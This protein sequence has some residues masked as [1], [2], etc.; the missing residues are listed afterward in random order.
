MNG[1]EIVASSSS[2]AVL[3][4]SRLPAKGWGFLSPDA[5]RERLE[6]E[7]RRHARHL[8]GYGVVR[9][10][11]ELHGLEALVEALVT[12]TRETDAVCVLDDGTFALL[13]VEGDAHACEVVVRRLE[14]VVAELST[15][16]LPAIR[17]G[18]GATRGRR[19]GAQD[20]WNEAARAF[21]QDAGRVSP[22]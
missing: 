6:Y 15:G 16:E 1:Q 10:D 7:A 19:V 3:A 13:V 20:V 5:F 11:V 18:V 22:Q 17:S 4:L 14:R 21:E 12:E 2:V 9:L 8:G